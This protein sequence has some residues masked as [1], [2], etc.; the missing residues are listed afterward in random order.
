MSSS[1]PYSSNRAA[2]VPAGKHARRRRARR[3]LAY[4][5]SGR[6][7]AAALICAAVGLPA[8]VALS[9]AAT[10]EQLVASVS[11][12]TAA[13]NARS[14]PAHGGAVG[15]VATVQTSS[16]TMTTST[17]QK[18]T[19]EDKA[20]TKYEKGPNSTSA[21]AVTVGESVLVLGTVSSRISRLPR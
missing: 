5:K 4:R 9:P 10:A 3:F 21:K 6:I 20:S 14:A 1:E 13:S 2:W 17:G 18:V 7:A 11:S 15:T 12:G 8:T 19:V 16:F